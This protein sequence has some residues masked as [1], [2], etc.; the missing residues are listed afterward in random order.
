MNLFAINNLAGK[1]RR[2]M[3]QVLTDPVDKLNLLA[4]NLKQPMQSLHGSITMYRTI[5]LFTVFLL[6]VQFQAA[7]SQEAAKDS[8]HTAN[9]FDADPRQLVEMPD[10][11]LKLMRED[12]LEHLS[13][14]N[15]IIAHLAANNLDAAAEIAESKMGKSSMGKHRGTGMGPGRFMPPEMRSIGRGMHEAATELSQHAKKG[16]TKNAYVALQKITG[17]CVACHYGY[18]TR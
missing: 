11:A 7:H 4:Y 17:S 15:E 9:A 18:R 16:D 14:L 5:I 10:Q 13:A 8:G 2:F 12:M 3:S 1:L 6:S